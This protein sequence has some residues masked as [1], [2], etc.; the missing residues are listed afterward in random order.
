MDRK[1]QVYEKE[2]V[3]PR[4]IRVAVWQ[5]PVHRVLWGTTLRAGDLVHVVA[6]NDQGTMVCNL[7]RDQYFLLW[8]EDIDSKPKPR[9]R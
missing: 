7:S 8:P 6:T 9:R 5:W 4:D 1:Q 2:V 3:L